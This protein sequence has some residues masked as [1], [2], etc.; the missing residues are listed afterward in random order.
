VPRGT[1]S[2]AY[3]MFVE[4]LTVAEILFNGMGPIT[5][6]EDDLMNAVPLENAKLKLQERSV[7]NRNQGLR[8]SLGQVAQT[9][10]ASTG[11]DDSFH[12][13]PPRQRNSAWTALPIAS[14]D[15]RRA[16]QPSW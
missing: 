9:C 12:V 7:A 15:V 3:V 5:G 11:E 10:P 16:C 14:S 1:F 13:C 8:Q 2:R 6:R 4:F